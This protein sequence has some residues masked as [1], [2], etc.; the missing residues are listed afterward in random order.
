MSHY[1]KTHMQ[2]G[3]YIPGTLDSRSQ[4]GLIR[5]CFDTYLTYYNKARKEGH[6]PSEDWLIPSSVF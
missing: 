3:P 5:K 1:I 6:E 2:I 4:K